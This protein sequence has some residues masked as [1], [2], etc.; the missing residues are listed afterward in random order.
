MVEIVKCSCGKEHRVDDMQLRECYYCGKRICTDCL[1]ERYGGSSFCSESCAEKF[2]KSWEDSGL[3]VRID[4]S[5]IHL[6]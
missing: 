1:I 3:D 2:K 4:Y 5:H 6:K